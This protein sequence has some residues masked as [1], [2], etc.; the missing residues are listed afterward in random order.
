LDGSSAQAQASGAAPGEAVGRA[1]NPAR[2]VAA[3]AVAAW[4]ILPLFFLVSGGTL[5]WWQ[6][7]AYCALCLVPMTVFFAYMMRHDPAFLARRLK[8]KEKERAQRLVQAWGFLSFSA[9]LV[10][11]GVDRRLGWSH[12]PLAVE[13]AALAVVLASYL[14][15]LWVFMENRWAGRTVEK[16]DEQ[17]VVSTGP[18]AIVRHPMY[19]G[20]IALYAATPP[21]L[22]SWWALLPVIALVPMFVMRI[23]NEE[24]VLVRELPGYEEYRQRVRYRLVPLLW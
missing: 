24:Q 19:V 8:V 23:L 18:Y 15:V 20:T 21:A 10:L 7:W 2:G 6:A 11:P 1:S 3:R 22:G 12:V 5:A 13:I 17:Q 14:A 4:V 9:I 16:F